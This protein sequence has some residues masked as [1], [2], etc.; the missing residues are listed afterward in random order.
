MLLG[1]IP[2]NWDSGAGPRPA[3]GLLVIA[4]DAQ[5]PFVKEGV[6]QGSIILTVAGKTLSD[7][8]QLQRILNDTAPEA[9]RIALAEKAGAGS[10]VSIGGD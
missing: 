1:A 2:H 10:V 7:V 5:S 9:C 6:K 3:A 8:I 4:I